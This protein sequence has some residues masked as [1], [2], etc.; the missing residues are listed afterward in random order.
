MDGRRDSEDVYWWRAPLQVI[1]TVN[2][3]AGASVH[4]VLENYVQTPII[5]R[6]EMGLCVTSPQ[7]ASEQTKLKRIIDEKKGTGYDNT[8]QHRQEAY[9][10]L[11]AGICQFWVS[12][13]GG[14]TRLYRKV[15]RYPW[16]PLTSP[17]W[18]GFTHLI[19]FAMDHKII[20]VLCRPSIV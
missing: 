9:R 13:G 1:Y 19:L 3:R 15:Q 12:N 7:R 16:G 17:L 14:S 11:G 4:R 10:F 18:L 20:I 5:R 8:R 6:A 2:R